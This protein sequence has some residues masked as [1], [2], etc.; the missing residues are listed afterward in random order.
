MA[1]TPNITLTPHFGKL[2][3]ILLDVLAGYLVY[4]TVSRAGH[5]ARTATLCS[6]LWLL[7]PLPMAVAARGNAESFMAVLV[8]FTLYCLQRGGKGLVT[9][10]FLF[11]YDFFFFF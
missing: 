3:F 1:L 5:P 8:L 4:L 10:I 6:Y 7:N 2:L 11:P 9:L